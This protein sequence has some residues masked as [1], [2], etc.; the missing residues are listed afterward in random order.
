MAP[1]FPASAASPTAFEGQYD[2]EIEGV[3]AREFYKHVDFRNR[4]QRLLSN[5]RPTDT[6]NPSTT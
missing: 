2:G 5:S 1:A 6:M 4:V 3:R